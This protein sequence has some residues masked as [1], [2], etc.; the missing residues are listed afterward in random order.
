MTVENFLRSRAPLST[1]HAVSALLV[2]EDSRTAMEQ[3][4]A[5]NIRTAYERGP[6]QTYR[7]I[8]DRRTRPE[9]FKPHPAQ[10]DRD[11]ADDCDYSPA[12]GDR[13]WAGGARIHL[14]VR[15]EPGLS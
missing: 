5:A 6:P 4:A 11:A 12:E 7:S 1:G 15:F 8:F 14:I 13:S 3:T 9:V 10:A 2:L